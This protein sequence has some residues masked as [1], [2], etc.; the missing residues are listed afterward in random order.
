MEKKKKMKR[1]NNYFLYVIIVI[2]P[3]IL[4]MLTIYHYVTDR[5]ETERLNDAKWIATIHQKNWNQFISE[6]VT[7]LDIL[8]LSIDAQ[9]D[10]EAV[11]EVVRSTQLTDMRYGSMFL[12][13]AT[14]TL[15][16][17]TSELLKDHD[18][19]NDPYIQEIMRTNDLIISE[20]VE[21]LTPEQQVIGIANP[22][23]DV[24]FQLER[25]VG[26]HLRVDYMQNIMKMLT[27]DASISI[28][29]SSGKQIMNMNGGIGKNDQVYTLPI[30]RLPWNIEVSV[31]DVASDNLLKRTAI[32]FFPLFILLHIFFFFIK[33]FMLKKHAKNAEKENEIQKLELVGNL[34][35][36]TA[37]EIR[38]PLTGVKGLIQLLS[39]KHKQE[40]DQY[41]FSIIN[42]EISRINEIVSEFLILGKPTIE[43]KEHIY[44]QDIIRELEPLIKSE[45]NLANIHYEDSLPEEPVG[46]YCN[47]DQM[48]QVFLN[49]AKNALESMSSNGYLS[50]SL[51]TSAHHC[52]LTIKDTGVGIPKKE[53]DRI[54]EPF[55]TSK[56]YGTGLGLVVCKRIVEANKGEITIESSA[57]KGTV[58]TII[59]P[60]DSHSFDA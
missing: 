1:K 18:F 54:F 38:N 42:N 9:N 51:T 37:H 24:N 22:I 36:S 7:T 34:A 33:Y 28:T 45:A 60:L 14:G 26:A 53:M 48:K 30:D 50:I 35:A 23:L 16:T 11:R 58:V 6:T 3:S 55:Y 43:K 56:D 8:A 31:S 10:M 39:E 44:V 4:G 19:N 49:I 21:T 52:Y 46:I 47:K 15:E 13:D 59:L 32:F 2:M 29:N 40:E 25:I 57:S 27:P 17:G 12:L 41:Y 5:E 20:E